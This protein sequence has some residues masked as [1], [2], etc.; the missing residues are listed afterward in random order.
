MFSKRWRL[1]RREKNGDDDDRHTDEEEPHS[2]A[3]IKLNPLFTD[4][5]LTDGSAQS[6]KSVPVTA[7]VTG[8][9]LK[10]WYGVRDALVSL[11]P[12]AKF[13]RALRDL[14]VDTYVHLSY[15]IVTVFSTLSEEGKRS[16]MALDEALSKPDPATARAA[17]L[18]LDQIV[19]SSDDVVLGLAEW[20]RLASDTGETYPLNDLPLAEWRFAIKPVGLYMDDGTRK[21][22][23]LAG[24]AFVVLV[25]LPKRM[26]CVE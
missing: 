12:L 19:Q 18:A 17:R 5:M 24:T 11:T 1:L 8:W 6:V 15:V 10:R 2:S 4:E 22:K 25:V 21:W 20:L 14:D 16:W 3:P 9:V 26:I 13:R 7:A 23:V